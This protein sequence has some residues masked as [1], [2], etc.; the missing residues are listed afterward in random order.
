MSFDM[1]YEKMHSN[2]ALTGRCRVLP[3]GEEQHES[4]FRSRG[5]VGGGWNP[6]ADPLFAPIALDETRAENPPENTSGA[7]PLLREYR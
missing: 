1:M 6:R 5:R 2:L 7:P 4:G 3:T